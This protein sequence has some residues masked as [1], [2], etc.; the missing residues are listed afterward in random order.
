M[1]QL[2]AV[3]IT[4]LICVSVLGQKTIIKAEYDRFKDQTAV[5]GE[6]QVISGI[7]KRDFS[8]SM[9]IVARHPGKEPVAPEDVTL[10]FRCVA[11][12]A[13]QFSAHP[14]L[15][16]IVDNERVSVEEVNCDGLLSPGPYQELVFAY[17]PLNDL[18]RLAK[19]RTVEGQLGSIE[20]ILTPQ[21][22]KA[23]SEVLGYFSR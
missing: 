14:T 2:Y 20:F 22:Q 12:Y 4:L 7:K 18:T 1:K 3:L 11:Q 19:A 10:I 17:V 23:I 6:R 5:R 21:N 13:Y 15:T 16:F 9:E 8:M